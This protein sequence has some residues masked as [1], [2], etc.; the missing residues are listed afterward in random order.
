MNQS[1]KPCN[2]FLYIFWLG[3]LWTGFVQSV[4]YVRDLHVNKNSDLHFGNDHWNCPSHLVPSSMSFTRGNGFHRTYLSEKH[5]VNVS[6]NS[7]CPDKIQNTN[8]IINGTFFG[9][10]IDNPKKVIFKDCNLRDKYVLHHIGDH[11]DALGMLIN[12]SYTAT[13]MYLEENGNLKFYVNKNDL[14]RKTFRNTVISTDNFNLYN[15]QNVKVANFFLGYDSRDYNHWYVN[16][17]VPTD[18]LVIYG[19]LSHRAF[20]YESID[21]CNTMDIV[22][23]IASFIFGILSFFV[24]G[25]FI[26]EYWQS[27][28]NHCC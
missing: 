23:V 16:I 4:L 5:P 3:I 14:M 10:I 28:E 22:M 20:Y 6:I 9:R 17:Y 8:I 18:P 26:V 7:Q 2:C 12:N 19:I 11:S 25:A 24:T 13:Q 15:D 27:F 21:E 1:E